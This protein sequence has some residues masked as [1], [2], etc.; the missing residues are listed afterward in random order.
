[1]KCTLFIFILEYSF[2]KGNA[3]YVHRHWNCNTGI[4]PIRRLR[5]HLPQGGRQKSPH[6]KEIPA[7]TI[8]LK[9][10]GTLLHADFSHPC[11]L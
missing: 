6:E 7:Q 2:P 1:M 8:A 5:R 11:F 4:F 3:I 10:P 9:Q